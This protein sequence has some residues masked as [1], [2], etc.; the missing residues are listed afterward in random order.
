MNGG[1]GGIVFDDPVSS[2]D[3]RRRERVAKRLAAEAVQRQ[4]IIFTHDI[5]FLCLLEEE[6]K[7]V[8]AAVVT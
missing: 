5:Y 3:H 2:L 7:R 1:K 8:G 4:V 6:A